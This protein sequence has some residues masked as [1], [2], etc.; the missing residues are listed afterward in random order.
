MGA[1]QSGI[2][3]A[4]LAAG[5]ESAETI[6]AYNQ[7][8]QSVAGKIAAG[9]ALSAT[10][11]NIAAVHQDRI[12]SNVQIRQAQDEAEAQA[13]VSAAYAGAVGASV[14]A[15]SH[16]TQVSEANALAANNSRAAQQIES[17]KANAYNSSMALR[18][19]VQT[20]ESSIGG[21]LLDALSSVELGDLAIAEAFF[22]EGTSRNV[23]DEATLTL[24]L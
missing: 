7:E 12:T 2:R 22:N 23:V 15:V 9:N 1:I 8:Y 18:S 16:Q 20:P 19:R 4:G 6:Q 13:K 3:L 21:G 17:L 11:R 10:E 14:S 5:V 24:T